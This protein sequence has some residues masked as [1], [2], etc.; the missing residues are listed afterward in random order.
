MRLTYYGHS[1]FSVNASGKNLLFDPYISSN[2]LAKHIDLKKIPADYILLSHGHIDHI[3][4]CEKIAKNTK[5]TAICAYEVSEWLCKKGV[6]STHPMNHGGKW[7]FEFG[8]V[9]T[10]N[11]VHSSVMPDGTYGGNPMGFIVSTEEK[12]FYYSGDTALTMDMQLV[13][14]WGQLDFAVLPIGDN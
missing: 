9:K 14:R 8:T 10:V 1:C 2:E 3:E 13:P 6:E 12:K 11:A 4:D 5:A 7:N